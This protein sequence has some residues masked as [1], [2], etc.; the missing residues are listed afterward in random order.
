MFS[1]ALGRAVRSASCI[2]A[3]PVG[4]FGRPAVIGAAAQQPFQRPS[5]HRRLSSSKASAPPAGSKDKKSEEISPQQA[6]A[7]ANKAS[8]AT[9]NKAPA[10]AASSASTGKAVG[11]PR[12]RSSATPAFNVPHVPP[13]DYLQQSGML[14]ALPGCDQNLMSQQSCNTSPSSPSIAPYRSQPQYRLLRQALLSTQSSK[15][16]RPTVERRC[17]RL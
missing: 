4:S 16:E 11:R 5:H 7:T 13:T 10:A 17:W 6:T 9:A 3:P 14:I 12:K 1:P 15:S 2:A 8:T